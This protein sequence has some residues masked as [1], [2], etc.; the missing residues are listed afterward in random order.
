MEGSSPT[1][2][3]AADSSP[4]SMKLFGFLVTDSPSSSSSSSITMQEEEN[5]DI[6]KRSFECQYCH[7]GFANSQALGGHQNAHKKERQRIKRAQFANIQN[8]RLFRANNNVP[9]IK[10]HS[11]APMN[12]GPFYGSSRLMSPVSDINFS[13]VLSGIPLRYNSHENYYLDDQI[14]TSSRSSKMSE[15]SEEVDVDLHL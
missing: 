10:P 9:I 8:H 12:L 15:V 4:N 1:A 5:E 3:A 2:T 6:I 11:A 14:G 7:R 13:Q